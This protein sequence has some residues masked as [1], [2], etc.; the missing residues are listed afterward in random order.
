MALRAELARLEE[1]RAGAVA[2]GTA[3]GSAAVAAVRTTLGDAALELELAES[4]LDAALAAARRRADAPLETE[5][6]R[7]VHAD[8]VRRSGDLS[9]VEE[10]LREIQRRLEREVSRSARG[11]SRP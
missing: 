8:L 11:T 7:R 2:A 1:P 5:S 10:Q 4:S 9:A 3:A 6:V